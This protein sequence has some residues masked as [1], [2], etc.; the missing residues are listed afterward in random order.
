MGLLVATEYQKIKDYMSG[1]EL[2]SNSPYPGGLL[3]PVATGGMSDRPNEARGQNQGHENETSREQ[4]LD[5]TV[6]KDGEWH[7]TMVA[8]SVDVLAAKND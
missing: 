5:E 4:D 2:L 6:Q 8:R 1:A 7:I 3:K